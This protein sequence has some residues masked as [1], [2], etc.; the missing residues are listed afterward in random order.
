M[1]YMRICG[2]TVHILDT[3]NLN[4][5]LYRLLIYKEN[6]RVQSVFPTETEISFVSDGEIYFHPLH[7]PLI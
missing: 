6:R 2:H 5:Y 7:Y 4:F 1:L 3:L